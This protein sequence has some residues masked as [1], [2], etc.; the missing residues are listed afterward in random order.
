MQ[1]IKV[2][3][4]E[5]TMTVQLRRADWQQA[6]KSILRNYELPP[7]GY[8]LVMGIVKRR[9]G[10][11]RA[12]NVELLF[13]YCDRREPIFTEDEAYDFFRNDDV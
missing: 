12:C 10:G 2:V 6:T 13:T 9:S 11:G 7:V 3:L 8:K 4:G 1:K 5:D